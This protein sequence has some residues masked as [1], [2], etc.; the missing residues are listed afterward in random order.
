MPETLLRPKPASREEVL[1]RYPR[2]CAHIICESLGYCTPSSAASIL[3]AVINK[4]KHY[5]EWLMSC[6]ACDPVL[7]VKNA[8]RRRRWH[9]GY[10][11]EFFQAFDLVRHAV[12]TG[13]EPVF[14]S[15]F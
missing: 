14:A 13:E 7:P 10:M 6:Y 4:E 11:S 3:L 5:C 2:I 1:Q 12:K 9:K 15:W 8:I